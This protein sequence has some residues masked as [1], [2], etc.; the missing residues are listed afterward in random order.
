MPMIIAIIIYVAY[1]FINTFGKNVAE[2]SKIS[3]LL[4][5]W[6]GTLIM[7]QL[8]IIFTISASK[9][10]GFIKFDVILPPF[11]KL[12]NRLKKADE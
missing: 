11:K 6:S 8:V 2:E 1:Y 7:L 9:D 3:A 12:F 5:G 10:M 4:G